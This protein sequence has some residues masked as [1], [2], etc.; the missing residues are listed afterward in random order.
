MQAAGLPRLF[1]TRPPEAIGW[2][3]VKM[4]TLYRT[5]RARRPRNV[6]EIGTGCSTLIIAEA[7]RRN[8]AGHLLTVDG[9]AR[10]LAE[11]EKALPPGS[12]RHVT[13]QHV[14]VATE[15]LHDTVC[16]RHL[17]LAEQPVDFI[18]LDGP[19]PKSAPDWPGGKPIASDPLHLEGG[20]QPGFA[21]LLEKRSATV[22]FLRQHFRRSY[23]MTQDR[24]FHL[25]QF[26][27]QA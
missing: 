21:M 10:W 2:S 15:T 22:A 12:L 8:G 14:P 5:I 4:W 25:T 26:E 27:L 23:R 3:S 13:L 18:Y 17:G 6:I 24:Y 19:D 20:F 16:L 1:E 11:T 7:L 9:S